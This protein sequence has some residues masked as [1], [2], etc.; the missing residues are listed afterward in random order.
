[1]F[2]HRFFFIFIFFIAII[3]GFFKIQKIYIWPTFANNSSKFEYKESKFNLSVVDSNLNNIFSSKKNM[4]LKIKEAWLPDSGTVMVHAATVIPLKSGGWRAFWYAGS[5]EGASDVVIKSAIW[6]QET[7]DWGNLTT[8]IDR[9]TAQKDLGRKVK[10][11]GNP[12]PV[13]NNEN[14][15]QLFFVTVPFGGWSVSSISMV[16]SNDEGKTWSKAKRLVTSPFLNISTLVKGSCFKYTDGT[17]GLPAYHEL[18]GYYGELLRISSNGAVISKRRMSMG[19]GTIQPIVFANNS[20]DLIAYFRNHRE[21]ENKK[22]AVSHSSNSGKSWKEAPDLFISNPDSAIAGIELPS[23]NRLMVINDSKIDRTSLGVFAS[24]KN[25]LNVLN[26]K[27]NNYSNWEFLMR[28]EDQGVPFVKDYE[29]PFMSIDDKGIICL[30]YTF[31]RKHIKSVFLNSH[32][33]DKFLEKRTHKKI[34]F[35]SSL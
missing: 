35:N 2:K 6:D 21:I 16:E 26:P 1:M 30:V 23:G 3:L 10:K 18:L 8:V 19:R 11:L 9:E 15:L 33:I 14:K 29:Y 22:I 17:V 4:N 28:L 25:N 5:R 12:L 7:N 34:S 31:E 32:S 20:N 27:K 24:I 13:Y